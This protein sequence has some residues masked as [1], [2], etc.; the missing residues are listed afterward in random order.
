MPT[1]SESD[2]TLSQIGQPTQ[3]D[4]V[5]CL[6][7]YVQWLQSPENLKVHKVQLTLVSLI[8]SNA[9]GEP[10]FATYAE[11]FLQLSKDLATLKTIL[12]GKVDVHFSNRIWFKSLGPG[13]LSSEHPFDP[14]ETSLQTVTIEVNT[15]KIT[16]S[17]RGGS[18]GTVFPQCADNLLYGFDITGHDS[19]LKRQ[20]LYIL[21][22]YK[23]SEDI[24]T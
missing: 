4:P 6:Q 3:V 10:G 13:A 24:V 15:G 17:E 20:P 7:Q 23:T 16:L 8:S 2:H 11:G 5:E 14:E 9:Q 12:I 1:I 18:K 21:T 19:P 22:L